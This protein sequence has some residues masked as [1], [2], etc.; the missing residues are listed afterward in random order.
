METNNNCVIVV[1]ID[2]HQL[3]CTAYFVTSNYVF[4]D[5]NC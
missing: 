3:A 5:E 4:F 2:C 1:A